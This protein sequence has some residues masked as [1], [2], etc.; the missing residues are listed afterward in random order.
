MSTK[1]GRSLIIA[2]MVVEITP[3]GIETLGWQ[4]YIVWTVLNGSFV[5]FTY[6]LYP[7]SKFG[8]AITVEDLTTA[9]NAYLKHSWT[10]R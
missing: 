9:I 10:I 6:F 1:R 4:F 2:S 5:P 3:I 7:E 8:Q